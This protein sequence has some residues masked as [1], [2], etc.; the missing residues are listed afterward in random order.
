MP[1]QSEIQDFSYRIRSAAIVGTDKNPKGV[2]PVLAD[3]IVAQAKHETGNFSSRAFL[4]DNNAF[5]YSY[6]AGAYWQI[7]PGII[8]DNGQP[9]ARYASIEDSTAEIVDWIYR[10][11]AEGKFPA[12][13]NDITTPD[14]YARLLKGA[15]YYGDTVS[16]YLEGLRRWFVLN[17]GSDAILI[18]GLALGLYALRKQLKK[19]LKGRRK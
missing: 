5:G 9:V 6:V 19:L 1:T 15:G 17:T 11:I 14:Q 18:L 16:N 2:P 3:L 12:N 4:Q 8:A 13:L 7:G 10:R